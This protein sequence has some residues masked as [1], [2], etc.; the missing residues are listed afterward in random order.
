MG[1]PGEAR[2]PHVVR[3]NRTFA[4]GAKTVTHGEFRRLHKNHK[5]WGP[6]PELERPV[7][8]VSWHQA[9]AYCNWL[10]KEMGIDSDQWCFETDGQGKV[11]ALKKDY[12]SLTGYRLPTEAEMEYATRAGASTSRCYGE[13]EGLLVKYGWIVPNSAGQLGPVGRLK[14]NDLGLFDVH[15]NV[16]CWCME[17]RRELPTG[18]EGQVFED[19]EFEVT[20]DKQQERVL[21]GNCYTDHAA[22]VGSF[23]RWGRLPDRDTNI[24][25][26]RLART[27]AKE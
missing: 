17:A 11:T 22:S 18:Q 16:W 2:P 14:P 12:L 20:I 13:S 4:I 7:V 8:N 19:R 26:F 3:I 6:G 24:I 27:I 23:S 9:A 21:R 5:A 25:G 10:S 1:A 15:G